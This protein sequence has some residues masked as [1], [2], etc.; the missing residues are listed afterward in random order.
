MKPLFLLIRNKGEYLQRIKLQRLWA[1]SFELSCRIHF[2]WLGERT[3][4]L[5]DAYPLYEPTL[6]TTVKKNNNRNPLS[7]HQYTQVGQVGFQKISV[8]A[9]CH[10]SCF[11]WHQVWDKPRNTRLVAYAEILTQLAMV[12]Y[13]RDLY[14]QHV[15][16]YIWHS[17]ILEKLTAEWKHILN[18]DETE[19]KNHL[20][21]W[22]EVTWWWRNT[23]KL[24]VDTAV[25]W[26]V[27]IGSQELPIQTLSFFHFINQHCASWSERTA[28][29]RSKHVLHPH[30]MSERSE[31]LTLYKIHLTKWPRI[32]RWTKFLFT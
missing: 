4:F 13:C 29:T 21:G 12:L 11:F 28:Y 1:T 7:T 22:L 17:V 30:Q 19:T 31:V 24:V 9:L 27:Q 25:V 20:I 8:M 5:S 26:W 2:R 18:G 6:K 16:H 32:S 23:T 14:Q 3:C 10:A 15:F